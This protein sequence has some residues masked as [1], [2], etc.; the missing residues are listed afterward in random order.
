VVATE[1]TE[2]LI[3]TEGCVGTSDANA[4]AG[5][6]SAMTAASR[7]PM[8]FCWTPRPG[9]RG[10]GTPRSCAGSSARKPTAKVAHAIHATIGMIVPIRKDPV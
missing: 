3:D 1:T 5:E 2:V 4:A 10:R 8:T 9:I 7:P 6:N